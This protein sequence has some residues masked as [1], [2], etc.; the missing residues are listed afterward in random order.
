MNIKISDMLDMSYN[1]W[2]EN[3]DNWRKMTPENAHYS[4]LY[5]IEEI[6]EAI[7]ILKKKNHDSIMNNPEIREKFIEELTDIIMYFSNVLSCFDISAEEFS[8]IYF[9]KYNK[10]LKRDYENQYKLFLNEN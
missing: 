2:L 10:N 9:K 7:Q 5:M 1:L 6:G 8:K 3:K 4:I